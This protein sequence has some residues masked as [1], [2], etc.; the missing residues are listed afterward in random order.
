[1]SYPT[2]N[3]VDPS[4]DVKGMKTKQMF[5]LLVNSIHQIYEGEKMHSPADYSKED[6]NKF[7]E[8]LDSKAFQKC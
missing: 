5:D 8:S 4:I 6:L 3:S 2:I 1:M 7:V